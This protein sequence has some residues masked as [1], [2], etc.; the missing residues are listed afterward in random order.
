MYC[1]KFIE[2]PQR[3][4]ITFLVTFIVEK[5]FQESFYFCYRAPDSKAKINPPEKIHQMPENV[6]CQNVKWQIYN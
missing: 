5:K 1:S 3:N 6:S 2:N 4:Q